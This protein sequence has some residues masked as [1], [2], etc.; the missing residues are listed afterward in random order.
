MLFADD[1]DEEIK[2]SLSDLSHVLGVVPDLKNPRPEFGDTILAQLLVTHASVQRKLEEPLKKE[3]RVF[4]E[5][6]VVPDMLNGRGDLHGACSAFLIDMC[7]SLCL[8]VL[9]RG[10]HVSQSLNVV[11]HSPASLG[12]K[13]R[14]INTT[15]TVGARA[16]SARTEIW[17][18]TQRRLVASGVHIKMQPSTPKL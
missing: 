10:M 16:M 12:E 5:I 3:G 2:R 17:N 14:I 7:S 13:L 1:I 8:M 18:A 11:Y 15:M 6:I 4:C 9:Q